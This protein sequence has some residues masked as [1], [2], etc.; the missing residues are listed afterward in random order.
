MRRQRGWM[1]VGLLVL[2]GCGAA[3]AAAPATTAAS[4]GGFTSSGTPSTSTDP[5]TPVPPALSQAESTANPSRPAP[6]AAPAIHPAHTA[7]SLGG[8]TSVVEVALATLPVKGRAARTGYS[9]A[10]LGQ[11]RSDDV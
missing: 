1:A 5:T 6:W 2:S 10:E 4:A 11:A 8:T 3:K 7:T 9:R